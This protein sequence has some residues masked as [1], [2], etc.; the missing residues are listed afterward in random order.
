MI[1]PWVEPIC[2]SFSDGTQQAIDRRLF[3]PGELEL[4]S[5]IEVRHH[6]GRG[7]GRLAD[8][9]ALEESELLDLLTDDFLTMIDLCR[10]EAEA[11]PQERS[12]AEHAEKTAL[13]QSMISL[14]AWLVGQ[15]ADLWRCR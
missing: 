2:L 7:D 11:E 3:H 9:Q 12:D 1:I 14:A 10:G 13:M 15:H 6:N 5:L 4:P 8:L